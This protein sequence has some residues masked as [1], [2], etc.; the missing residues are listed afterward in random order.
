MGVV[1]HEEPRSSGRWLGGLLPETKLKIFDPK[2]GFG[3][4]TNIRTFTDSSICKRGNRW[5]MV[6]GGFEVRKGTIL[7]LSASLPPGTPLSAKGW[8]IAT[9]PG[10]PTTAAALVPPS[11]KGHWEGAGGMHCPSYVR[12]W[13]PAA[14]GNAGAW[15]ERICYGDR[16]S[17]HRRRMDPSAHWRWSPGH[18][19]SLLRPAEE[20]FHIPL[21]AERMHDPARAPQVLIRA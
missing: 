10:D 11:P 9:L 6:A 5:W 2:D 12:G 16:W 4:I 3:A 14:N 18:H 13:D 21:T 1:S 8:A 20:F 7:L 15:R 17:R 19:A